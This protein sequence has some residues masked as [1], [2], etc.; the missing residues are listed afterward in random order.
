MAKKVTIDNLQSEL[1]KI[2]QDYADDVQG[3]IDVIARRMGQK[4]AQAL[5]NSS[6]Q[7]FDG[8]KYAKGWGTTVEKNRLYTVVY[9][10]NKKQAGLAHLLE[11]GHVKAN[12]TGRYGFWEGREHI[13]PVEQ[14]IVAT[15]EKEVKA[16]L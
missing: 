3:N 14:E 7:T 13:A 5:K 8:E 1:D 12:G 6:L 11:H 16:S 2:L 10:H 15:Y 4:G 9:I